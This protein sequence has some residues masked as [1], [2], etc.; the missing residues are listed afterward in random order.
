M[1]VGVGLISTMVTDF[2]NGNK[3]DQKHGLEKIAI[4][5][6]NATLHLVYLVDHTVL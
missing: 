5:K 4:H 1:K 2:Q 3:T 6:S